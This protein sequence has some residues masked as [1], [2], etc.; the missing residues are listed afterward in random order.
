M[1]LLTSMVV[2]S[3]YSLNERQRLKGNSEIRLTVKRDCVI[4]VASKHMRD[5]TIHADCDYLP[6]MEEQYDTRESTPLSLHILRLYYV[7]S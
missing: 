4:S 5:E 1:C 2:L 6:R 3:H 7:F